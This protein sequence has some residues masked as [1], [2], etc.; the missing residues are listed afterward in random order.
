VISIKKLLN[1]NPEDAKSMLHVAQLLLQGIG[2]HS[3]EGDR[4]E[5]LQFRASLEQT[6]AALA[7]CRDS[8]QAMMQTGSAIRALEDYNRRTARQLQ[9][10]GSELQGM[11]KMLTSAIGE[12]STAGEDN[13]TR[14]RRIEGQVSTASQVE[15]VRTIRAQLSVCLDE[16]RKETE[17]QNSVATSAVD[18][19]R[20][21]LEKAQTGISSDSVTGLS[22]R[23]E[24]VEEIS[25]ACESQQPAFAV[26]MVIERLQTVN[27]TF[28]AEVGDQ[29]LRYFS[30][31]VRR[32]LPSGDHLFRWT[33]AS[34]LALVLRPAQLETVREEI[35]RLM[36]RKLEHTVV[37]AKRSIL[38]P[39]TARW[40]LFPMMTSSR[41][42]IQKIDAFAS[43]QPTKS[44]QPAKE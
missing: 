13:V 19:L 5:Y 18:R 33:G 12:I 39:V 15:D 2:L 30:G 36:E 37:T 3:I 20:R 11:V 38:L 6:A 4:E 14:L 32:N 1:S 42:L 16:I 26:V 41:L 34:V 28:G 9:V 44:M 17:R 10:R 21:D 29:L 27:A 24:A 35:K 31:H 40:A 8:S 22:L 23:S 7:N 43:M 25:T